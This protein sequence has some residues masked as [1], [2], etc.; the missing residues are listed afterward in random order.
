MIFYPSRNHGSFTSR[1][2]K[3][4]FFLTNG[5]QQTFIQLMNDRNEVVEVLRVS[6]E[7]CYHVKIKVNTQEQLNLFGYNSR[8]WELYC[9]F[10]HKRD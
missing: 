6:G 4:F 1:R 9:T 5:K 10:I 7:A 8:V 3:V 2:G